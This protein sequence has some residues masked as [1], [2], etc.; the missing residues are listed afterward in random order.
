VKKKYQVFQGEENVR[1]KGKRK[2]KQ[3]NSLEGEWGGPF[4]PP[5]KLNPLGGESNSQGEK[6]EG[7]ALF[8]IGKPGGKLSFYED[9]HW[10]HLL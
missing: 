10:F 2:K 4:L 9:C 1:G 7:E 8:T 3:S 5:P 6:Q